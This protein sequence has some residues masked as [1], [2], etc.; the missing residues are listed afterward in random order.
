MVLNKTRRQI[1][2]KR[3]LYLNPIKNNIYPINDLPKYKQHWPA[4]NRLEAIH[5]SYTQ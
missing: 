4:R 5:N 2:P 1:L 3:K